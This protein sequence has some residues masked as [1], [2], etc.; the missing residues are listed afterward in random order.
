MT[1]RRTWC[2]A[3]VLLAAVA[4]ACSDRGAGD[5]GEG[6]EGGPPPPAE[7]AIPEEV[8]EELVRLGIDDQEARQDLS[9]ERMQ[10]TAWARATLRGD[11]MR[12][13]RLRAIVAE[14]GWPYGSRAGRE[15]ADAAFLILQHS[16]AHDF[17]KEMLPTVEALAREGSIPS[18]D[19]A[20][21]ID[22]VLMHDGLPQRYGTQFELVEGRWVLH[23]VED[24]EGLEER[25]RSMGL[26]GMEEYMRMMEA[27]Y[28]AP[29]VRRP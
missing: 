16:P 29:V 23:P 13:A 18:S 20:L 11:S 21:L 25:R 14:Y 6:R 1:T 9:P 7:R 26:P 8:R 17:Q 28:D 10:D 24:E 19:A 3:A 12:T 27:V 2:A 5:A 15:A 22:R 4:G